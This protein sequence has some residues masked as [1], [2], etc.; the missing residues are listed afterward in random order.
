MSLYAITSLAK[1]S[2]F[3]YH[4]V[5]RCLQ[6]LFLIVYSG[7]IAVNGCNITD[8]CKILKVNQRF[9]EETCVGFVEISCGVILSLIYSNRWDMLNPN[10]IFF[11]I[12]I[13]VK[14]TIIGNLYPFCPII[15]FQK[16]IIC[17][18]SFNLQRLT[19]LRP[20]KSLGTISFT[21]IRVNIC[22]VHIIRIY[23]TVSIS[24]SKH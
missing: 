18:L 10:I 7:L 17:W 15:C 1:N 2:S 8:M 21:I 22:I 9:I 23:Y 20:R 11:L 16:P 3:L 14:V 19:K 13:C 24:I 5:H 6:L 12:T 4:I